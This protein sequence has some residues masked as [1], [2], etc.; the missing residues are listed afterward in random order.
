MYIVYAT[1]DIHQTKPVF[2]THDVL[3]SFE[4]AQHVQ[5]LA[6]KIKQIMDPAQFLD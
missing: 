2:C 3:I 6:E 5:N 4:R 1:S